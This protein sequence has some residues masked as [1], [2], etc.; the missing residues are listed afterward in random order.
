MC[1]KFL[2]ENDIATTRGDQINARECYLNSLRKAE[3]RD[4]N[5]ILLDIYMDDVLE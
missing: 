2:I 4:V 1:I 5:I 3:P